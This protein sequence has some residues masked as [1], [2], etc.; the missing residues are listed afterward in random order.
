MS[1]DYTNVMLQKAET[2]VRDKDVKRFGNSDIK[3]LASGAAAGLRL[4][5]Y[6]TRAEAEGYLESGLPFGTSLGA[7]ELKDSVVP[8]FNAN[9]E[10]I[11]EYHTAS[12]PQSTTLLNLELIATRRRLEKGWTNC[13][14]L[15]VFPDDEKRYRE[16]TTLQ[17]N[18]TEDSSY[19]REDIYVT[20]TIQWL[21]QF[22]D[23]TPTGQQIIPRAFIGGF[24]DLDK[25]ELVRNIHYSESF[26]QS[27]TAKQKLPRLN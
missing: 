12:D 25:M 23:F 21:N 19:S 11:L 9:N 20:F 26:L 13:T 10:G 2:K 22:V 27:E 16:I 5:R 15:I 6:C 17:N 3:A 4:V 18:S 8:L 7:H 24:I 14:L 1:I